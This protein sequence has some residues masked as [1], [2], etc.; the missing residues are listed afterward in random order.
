MQN[1]TANAK[2]SHSER[3]MC[4]VYVL[5][6]SRERN[7][8]D[9][10]QRWQRDRTVAGCDLPRWDRCSFALL[11]VLMLASSYLIHQRLALRHFWLIFLIVPEEPPSSLVVLFLP[12]TLLRLPIRPHSHFRTPS[13]LLCLHTQIFPLTVIC[14]SLFVLISCLPSSSVSLHCHDSFWFPFQPAF[15]PTSL[16][17]LYLLPS[18]FS[19]VLL[20]LYLLSSSICSLRLFAS[21]LSTS[22]S[23]PL[24]I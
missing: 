16:Y 18:L 23:Q 11:V 17:L 12:I 9:E 22:L 4:V 7:L 13:V 19:A 24:H 3:V 20:S 5:R 15:F 14:F 10:M 8:Q 6:Q 1:R 21:L 2:Q